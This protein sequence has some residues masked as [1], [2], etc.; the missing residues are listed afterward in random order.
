[1]APS[2]PCSGIQPPSGTGST[3]L[4]KTTTSDPLAG[5]AGVTAAT[6]HMSSVAALT[7]PAAPTT[8]ANVTFGFGAAPSMPTGCLAVSPSS[9]VWTVSCANGGTYH[10]GLL[11]VSGGATLNFATSGSGSTYTF[12]QGVFTQGGTNTTFGAGTF[13]IG[14]MSS[15]CNGSATYSICNTGTSLTFGGPSTFVISSG[16]SNGGGTII[17][18]GSGSTNSYQIGPGS[19]GN[20]LL[21]QGGAR[22]T[23][24]DATGVSDLFQLKGAVN[25]GGGGCTILPAAAQHDINGNFITSGGVVMGAG[26]YT[27]N[28][29]AGFGANSGGDASCNGST[30]GVSGAGVTLVISGVSTPTSGVCSGQAFCVAS[31][32]SNV[33][34]TAPSSGTTSGLVVLG[35]A[36]SSIAAGALFTGGASGTSLSGVFYFPDGPIT[37]GGGASIGNGANQCLELIGTQISLTGGTAAASTCVGGGSGSSGSTVALVQ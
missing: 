12:S 5:S 8:G 6:G 20:A 3:T 32:F 26:V 25:V 10:F 15:G 24:A 35:P 16:V 7:A 36:S 27:V 37:L 2:Q 30:V 22:M 14:P 29:Y 31:G 17:V 33:T 23:L 4:T 13:N 11:T 9:G 1:S 28:G 21:V 19:D 18:M 34:L